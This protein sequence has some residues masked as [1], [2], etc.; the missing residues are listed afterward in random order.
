MGNK[1][2]YFNE[3]LPV[4]ADKNDIKN[5]NER[6]RRGCL[7]REGKPDMQTSTVTF[8]DGTKVLAISFTCRDCRDGCPN[9]ES[10]FG[11]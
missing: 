5:C 10:E 4:E 11:F 6:I 2:R 3:R 1:N 7:A 9:F 8:Q